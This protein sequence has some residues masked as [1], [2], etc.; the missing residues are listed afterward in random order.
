VCT[1]PPAP[2]GTA[3]NDGNAC[4]TGDVCNGGACAG[5]AVTDPVE[6]QNLGA[7]ADKT[8]YTWSAVANA[9]RY[10]VGRGDLGSFPV[11]PGGGD[12]ACFDDLVG[13]NLSDTT[14][15]APGSGFWYVSR[16]ESD[17]GIGPFG[18]RSV[19]SP[20]ITTTCP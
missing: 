1:N 18:N 19:G 20:R 14:I 13:P 7:A 5:T 16:G 2:E 12:E 6:T 17:C 15:P 8:T 9:T 10:D 11:G 3:C 4:T